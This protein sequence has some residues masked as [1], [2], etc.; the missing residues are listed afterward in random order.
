VFCKN[1]IQNSSYIDINFDAALEKENTNN[2]KEEN[3][4]RGFY[5]FYFEIYLLQ[6]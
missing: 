6:K 2:E 3:G 5:L 1:Q 4:L